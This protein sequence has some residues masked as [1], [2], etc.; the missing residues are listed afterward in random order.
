MLYPPYID[1]VIPAFYGGSLTV[2]FS[3]NPG[4]GVGEIQGFSLKIKSIQ[5]TKY[6]FTTTD[7]AE[8]NLSGNCYVK[9]NISSY[10]NKMKEGQHYKVQ[11]AYIGQDGVGYYS[12]V[13]IIK[14][15]K[16]PKVTIQDLKGGRINA[17][18]YS[19][20][21][22]YFSEDETEK[23][24]QYSFIF[25]DGTGQIL[26]ETGWQLHNSSNDNLTYQSHDEFIVPFDLDKNQTYYIQY[27]VITNNKL[28]VSSVKYRIH[29][30][31]SINPDIK[32]EL[33]ADMYKDNGYV[34][35]TMEGEYDK[36]DEEKSMTGAFLI[37]R[38]S[39]DSDFKT[40][41]EILRF[42]ATGVYP[43]RWEYKDFTVEQG[44]KYIYSFQQY[45][46]FNLYS[47]RVLSNIIFSDFED[48][49]LYDGNRQLK[50]SYN[51]QV[52]SFKTDILESKTETLGNRYPFILRNGL[53]EYKEFPL[54]GLISYMSDEEHLFATNKELGLVDNTLERKT[55]I[56]P[57]FEPNDQYFF[58][59]Q[60]SGIDIF[61]L[62]ENYKIAKEN[63]DTLGTA[64]L[65]TTS[66]VD[67]NLSA[68][69]VFKLKV[70]DW[71]NN[72]EPKLFR[73]ASEGNYIVRLM[74]VSLSP[75]DTLGRMLH[76]FS[77][78]AYEIDDCNYSTLSNYGIVKVSTP[79]EKVL[80]F[81]TKLLKDLKNNEKIIDGDYAITI[82]FED[83]TPGDIIKIKTDNDNEEQTIV[84]GLTGTYQVDTG[85]KI[86]S[87]E[88]E[89]NTLV[90]LQKNGLNE[91]QV[92][93]GYYE[94]S[95]NSFNEIATISFNDIPAKQYIG[96][97]SNIIK[98]INN[99]KDT[100]ISFFYL[101]FYKRDIKD[102]EVKV[103]VNIDTKKQYYDYPFDEMNPFFLYR[104][105]TSETIDNIKYYIPITLTEKDFSYYQNKLPND[106]Y[107]KENDKYIKFNK[108]QKNIQYYIQSPFTFLVDLNNIN[109][110]L[111]SQ[112][113]YDY[114]SE[115]YDDKE[116]LNK[117]YEVY[118]TEVGIDFNAI[119]LKDTGEY[120][121][122]GPILFES[123][124]LTNGVL[125]ECGYNVRSIN[126]NVENTDEILQKQYQK[127]ISAYNNIRNY[128]KKD[129]LYLLTLRKQYQNE[130]N[131]YYILLNNLREESL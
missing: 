22:S 128:D 8:Y 15:T 63:Y 95:I 39:E 18:K 1:G 27:K 76:N 117:L 51:P 48:M 49:F 105:K 38:S 111:V 61:Q 11:I 43:S 80:R 28:C 84:I 70:L 6:L 19:Y 21:G 131:K 24:Y 59:K 4:V 52:Q 110:L 13:G 36:F 3:M 87:A 99:I 82:K 126:Y 42:R 7:V 23:E 100:L 65:P 107:I 54:S 50:I 35:L 71:L 127:I 86:L 57:G 121:I 89:Q 130:K 66:L 90:K 5:N 118:S 58:D 25:S 14:Y 60:Y 85:A 109:K 47:E 88:I 106:Y 103:K 115:Y 12:T 2:P 31:Q 10:K 45:N 17:A 122:N 112:E 20:I 123:I 44:K 40:W 30:Q 101:H 26:K 94:S 69:R 72:G 120:N 102:I 32:I 33:K 108:W 98:Q 56:L 53:V 73:S 46:D 91:P 78:T 68:E 37:S 79:Q 114:L 34:L 92:T 124:E 83:M 119:D 62:K 67:Y 93:Y 74:N 75:E 16:K 97:Q 9:F 125:L 77:C 29:Q 81:K 104:F 64:H 96:N 113:E 55:T 116:Q 41:E 129:E